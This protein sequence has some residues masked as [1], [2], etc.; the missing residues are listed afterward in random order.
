MYK[1]DRIED[2]L[3]AISAGKVIIVCDD[4]DRENEGDL[5]MAAEKATAETVNFM[6]KEGR[7]L[8]CVP[9]P[10]ERLENLELE[11]MAKQNTALHGTRF[12]VSVD[13][14]YGTTTGISASDRARTIKVLIDDSS[15]PSDLARPGH[16]FPL[17]AVKGGVL[18]RAGHT[19]ATVDLARL[20]GLKPGGVLCEIMDE[21]G[22]M[23]RV[24]KLMEFAKKHDLRIITVKDLIEYRQR[25]ERLVHR[26]TE[27]D[28]PT[29]Y[30]HFKLHLYKSDIDAYHHLALV[31]GD[32]AGKEDVMVRVHSQCLTGDVFHSM[33]CDCGDQ[34]TSAMQMVEN[35]GLGVVLYMRQEGRGIGLANKLKAYHLQENGLDT[36]EANTELGF[37]PDLR[38]YGIGAQILKDLGL[39]TIRILTNNPKK[40]VGLQGYGLK[41][42]DRVR[43]ECSNNKFNVRYLT[44]KRD[45]MGHLLELKKKD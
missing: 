36:V 43:L 40:I 37:K 32:V 44:T 20:A 19:E 1:F 24:P 18:A 8:I 3:D 41:V 17:Q 25:T 2:A 31:K 27:V 39:T 7:G 10:L 6:A 22:R 33:R 5:I 34:I 15:K 29:K 42:T 9:L 4:E 23:A 12:H 11:P 21:D 38:D 13:A 14:V 16:V 30:G 28:L 26:V 45:K 35:E